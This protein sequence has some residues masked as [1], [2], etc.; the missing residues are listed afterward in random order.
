MSSPLAHALSRC[1]HLNLG[2][3]ALTPSIIQQ[4]WGAN[5]MIRK[6]LGG[7]LE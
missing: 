5:D 7:P 6:F 3:Q 4:V 1:S 2:S